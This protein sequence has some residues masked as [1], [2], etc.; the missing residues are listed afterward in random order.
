MLPL[1]D[2]PRVAASGTAPGLVHRTEDGLLTVGLLL[3]MGLPVAEMVLRALGRVG[4]VG[5]G[6]LVQHLTLIVGML[7]ALVATR[8]GR[9]LAL[10]VAP[11][12]TTNDRW[13]LRRMLVNALAVLVS[14]LLTVGAVDYLQFERE[15]GFTLALGIPAWMAQ[16]IVP[17]GFA[18]MATRLAWRAAPAA[19]GRLV[20]VLAAGALGWVV[21]GGALDWSAWWPWAVLVLGVA[22][23][24]GAPIFVL[25]AGTAMALMAADD[26]P[27]AAI[28]LNHIEL[29]T[30]PTLPAIPLFTAAGY[31]LAESGAPTR[32]IRV[33]HALFGRSHRGAVLVTVAASTFFT[34]FT[35]ASGVTILALGGLLLP[36]LLSSG[37]GERR[38]LALVT[39]AGAPGALVPPALP[40]ILYA[41]V[42][43][44]SMETLFLAGV[45]PAVVLFVLCVLWGA[46]RRPETE[47]ARQPFDATELAA[48]AWAAKW[49]LALPLL[50]L[51]ALFGGLATAVET[52]AMAAVAALIIEV[53][54]HR[55]IH[56][57][58]DLPRVLSQC[59]LLVGG[60]LL[61]LGVAM[62]LT[63]TLIDAQVPELALE[64]VTEVIESPVVFLLALNVLLLLVGCVMDIFSA[65][66]VLV[67][68][69]VP[70]G[71]AYGI[72]APHLAMVFL[73]NLQLGYLT[74]PVGMNLFFSAYRFER[75]VVDIYRAVWPLFL[76]LGAGVLLITYVPILSTWLPGMFG[77]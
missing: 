22:A 2:E 9:L 71:E 74:P 30:N 40:I 76:V 26:L 17:V 7:G 25:I 16:A 67:P 39:G 31:L 35:G 14:T 11:R 29:T 1:A 58:R 5:G 61:V 48:A 32:L 15:S 18:L 69:L 70:L 54:V 43:Q 75:P 49:E 65:I 68:L 28:A 37:L 3:L 42:A 55:D 4:I 24:A 45:L 23:V 62:G 57:T 52:A 60:V 38:G 36:L 44:G 77:P 12:G 66:V 34:C 19:P 63:N 8:E 47:S 33:F 46:W 53:L 13:P 64:W 10:S 21:S 50:V 51:V 6:P 56:P 73:A 27:L 59:G 41:T 72:A 20:T